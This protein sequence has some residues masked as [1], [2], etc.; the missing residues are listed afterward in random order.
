[1]LLNTEETYQ[2]LQPF[3][4]VEELNQNTKVVREK[5]G[6]LLT[7]SARNV[8]DVLHRYSCKFPGV[9]FLS[10]SKIANMLEISRRT[11]IRACALLEKLGIIKQ[12]ETKRATGDK[13]QSSNAIVFIS[14]ISKGDT[15]KSHTKKTPNNTQIINNTND[16]EISE[17]SL[18][19]NLVSNLPTPLQKAL[20]PFFGLEDLY[21]FVGIIYK[22]K[23]SVDRDIKLE[24]YE[25]DYY[26]SII[27]VIRMYKLGKVRNFEALL[28]TA[29]KTTTR[30]IWHRTAF[31]G[32]L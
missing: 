18:K 14:F 31:L 10:K 21:K 27:K 4:S 25:T 12:H 20:A 17:K 1:M 22:A 7:K 3:S 11:V 32:A 2:N 9:C 23:A 16:T 6:T 24:N 19:K 8:L 15:P 13:R 29:I 28:Y 26:N 30:S 5:F